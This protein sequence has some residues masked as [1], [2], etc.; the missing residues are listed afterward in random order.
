MEGTGVYSCTLP[1]GIRVSARLGGWNAPRRVQMGGAEDTPT[2]PLRPC[3]CSIMQPGPAGWP[4][5]A[6]IFDGYGRVGS[7]ACARDIMMGC[8][9]EALQTANPR[10]ALSAAFDAVHQH[11]CSKSSGSGK[12]K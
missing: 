12:L 7:P 4:I 3:T 10:A 11:I 2:D 9:E 5:A 8:V 6:Q 1:I